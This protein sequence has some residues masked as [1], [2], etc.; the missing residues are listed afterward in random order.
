M[1]PWFI[2]LSFM[3]F[4]DFAVYLKHINTSTLSALFICIWQ[5][6][7]MITMWKCAF[8]KCACRHHDTVNLHM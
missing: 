1:C 4:D 5:N 8:P 6:V 7:K 3:H 2:H